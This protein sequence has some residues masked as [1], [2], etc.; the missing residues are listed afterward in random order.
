MNTATATVNGATT[1]FTPCTRPGSMNTPVLA[2]VVV[3]V[4][5]DH[6]DLVA[7]LFEW[8]NL[9]DSCTALADDDQARSLV[10]EA[11][12][13]VGLSRVEAVRDDIE[14]M[15]AGDGRRAWLTLCRKRVTQLFP[16]TAPRIRRR[17]RTVAR[18]LVTA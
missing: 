18:E 8:G 13:N 7:A 9:D 17:Q 14:G 16:A 3:S 11:V 10:V 12:V 5:M 15:E 1:E 6:D 4:P 2:T